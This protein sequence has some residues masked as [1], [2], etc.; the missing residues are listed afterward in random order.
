LRTVLKAVF[1]PDMHNGEKPY[2]QPTYMSYNGLG[3]SP[4]IWGVPYMFGMFIICAS[5][6]PALFLG[7][8]VHGSGWAFALIAIPLLIFAKSLCETDDRAI[9]I[10]MKEIKWAILKMMGGNSRLYNGMFTIAPMSYG[11]KLFN[12]KRG[13]TTPVRG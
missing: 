11:R 9:N 12:V 4:A 3:R 5:L 10:L 1:S 6:L 13:I 8:F 2:E 7:T